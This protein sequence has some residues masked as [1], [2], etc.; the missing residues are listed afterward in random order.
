M[1][2]QLKQIMHSENNAAKKKLKTN[3]VLSLFVLQVFK[4]PEK[5][6]KFMEISE[7]QQ[8]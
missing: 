7:L 3:L 1:E 2:N 6:T 5:E 8:E 4:L